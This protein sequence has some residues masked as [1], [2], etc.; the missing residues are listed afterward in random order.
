MYTAKSLVKYILHTYSYI[1]IYIYLANTWVCNSN[2]LECPHLS[3][4]INGGINHFVNGS[5][6]VFGCDDGYAL[7][8]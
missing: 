2:D 8:G 1:Y 6:I 5:I 7:N 4:P 3:A